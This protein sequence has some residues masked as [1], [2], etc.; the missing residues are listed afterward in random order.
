LH[1]STCTVAAV[2][3]TI[4]NIKAVGTKRA[5]VADTDSG[6]GRRL[7]AV[8]ATFIASCTH[9]GRVAVHTPRLQSRKPR[10]SATAIAYPEVSVALANR[11]FASDASPARVAITRGRRYDAVTATR[12][13]HTIA[14]TATDLTEFAAEAMCQRRAVTHTVNTGSF[15]VAQLVA[16]DS[17]VAW[18]AVTLGIASTR[19]AVVADVVATFRPEPP[20]AARNAHR[21]PIARITAGA[22]VVAISGAIW[23]AAASATPARVAHTGERS[24]V[25]GAMA[26]TIQRLAQEH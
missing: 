8:D 22:A 13:V 26:R 25:A 6:F 15:I 16:I 20:T 17:V 18:I 24:R 23:D 1:T 11:L 12:T 4:A 3:M 10:A 19:H 14:G 7:P 21:G 9:P 5:G 2:T